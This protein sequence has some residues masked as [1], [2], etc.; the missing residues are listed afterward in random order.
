MRL[1]EI[2]AQALKLMFVDSEMEFSETEF[3][4]GT[5]YDN[6]N[7]KEKLVRME[8]S[9]RRGIDLYYNL[10]GVPILVDMFELVKDEEEKYYNKIDVSLKELFGEPLR[11]N[12]LLYVKRND[13]LELRRILEN[14]NFVYNPLEKEISFYDEDYAFLGEVVKFQIWYRLKKENIPLIANEIE[15]DLDILPI[16]SEVQRMLPYFIKAEA[17]EEDEPQMAKQSREYYIS[18]LH[19]LPKPFQ[20]VQTKVKKSKIFRKG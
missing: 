20:K 2:K 13:V 5:V 15:Y 1:W 17:Y 14:I 9:I 4:S 11:I 7:T 16:P 18:F 10:V 8:D 19:T 6:Y 3:S 12:A